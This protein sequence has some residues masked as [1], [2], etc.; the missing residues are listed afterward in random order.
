MI[1]GVAD[2]AAF[3]PGE[4]LVAAETRPDWEPVMKTAGAIVTDHGGR[5]CHAAIVA[6]ELG[7]PAVVGSE[8]ATTK[9]TTGSSV[10]VSCAGGEDGAVYPGTLPFDVARVDA[11]DLA[12]PKT[13]IMVNLGNPDLAFR[14]AMMPNAG[15]GLARMEFIINEYIGIHPMAL[16]HPEQ[17]AET[18]RSRIA[19]LTVGESSPTEFFVRTLAEGVGTIAAAFWPR[20]VTD[21]CVARLSPGF[22]RSIGSD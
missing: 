4:V 22:T 10:T 21:S 18:D 3:R 1:S 20:P 6:R 15:V 14:T 2:L 16:V 5:T 19:A 12:M 9:L 13:E 17:V 8:A 11:R 7:V